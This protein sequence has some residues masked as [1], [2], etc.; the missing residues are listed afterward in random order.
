[1]APV[2]VLRSACSCLVSLARCGFPALPC[3]PC[4]LPPSLGAQLGRPCLPARL[5]QA[6][7]AGGQRDGLLG[8]ARRGAAGH[9]AASWLSPTPG[10]IV[11]AWALGI[12]PR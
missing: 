5:R 8:T 3:L 11:N 6:L 7:T 10:V 4:N 1:M 9:G 2:C 12:S